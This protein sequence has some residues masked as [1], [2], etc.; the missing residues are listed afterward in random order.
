MRIF[1]SSR[2]FSYTTLF[3]LCL[4]AFVALTESIIAIPVAV[5]CLGAIIA[6]GVTRARR[7]RQS[8]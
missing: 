2:G 7:R 3:L 4:A 6:L 5:V 1:L 8:P